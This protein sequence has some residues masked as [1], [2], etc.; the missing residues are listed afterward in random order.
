MDTTSPIA[1]NEHVAFSTLQKTYHIFQPFVNI[2]DRISAHFFDSSVF[3]WYISFH[4]DEK[5][6]QTYFW[7]R[8]WR[9]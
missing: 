5:C 4:S 6:V 8:E 1:D 2:D 9:F 7:Q 3:L